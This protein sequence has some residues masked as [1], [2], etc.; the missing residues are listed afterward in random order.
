[1]TSDELVID[2]GSGR[3]T[4]GPVR[5]DGTPGTM[6]HLR[7][8]MPGCV[9][10]FSDTLQVKVLRKISPRRSVHDVQVVPLGWYVT[11]RTCK[12][13]EI[14]ADVQPPEAARA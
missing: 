1:M 12:H 7:G 5:W 11:P 9:T 2:R 3:V 10:Y 13:G 4:G 8:L 14:Y 6:E